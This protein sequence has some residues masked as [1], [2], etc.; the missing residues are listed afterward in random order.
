[1]TVPRPALA[2]AFA[3]LSALALVLRPAPVRAQTCEGSL[4][5]HVDPGADG[6]PP[7]TRLLETWLA[8]WTADQLDHPLLMPDDIAALN[9]RNED[10]IGAWHDQLMERQP[11]PDSVASELLERL[12]ELGRR[13]ATG[14]YVEDQPGAFQNVRK[15]IAAAYPAD[16]IRVVHTVTDFR[17]VPLASGL[18]RKHIDK[19]FDRNQCSRLHPGEIVRVLRKSADGRW[20]YGRAGHGVGWLDPTALGPPMTADAMRALRDATPR[21]TILDDWI[22][23]ER[24]DGTL[25][26]LR[27]GTGFP[28][29]AADEAR[30]QILVPTETGW[31][32]AFVARAP[33]AVEGY[34]PLTRRAF[35]ALL[36]ARLGDPYGW[37]GTGSGR[38]CSGL[39]LDAAASFDLRLGRNSSIQGQAGWTR[40]DVAG[41]ADRDKLAAIRA[42]AAQGVVFLYMPG[43][44]MVYLGELDGR[45]YAISAISEYLMP[46]PGGGHRTV[47]LDRTEVTD[48]ERGRGTERKAFIERITALSI[49]GR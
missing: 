9:S 15:T 27:F 19:L 6:T 38:D 12:D 7:V 31:D 10:T 48:L 11:S 14:E 2:L 8:Q 44:I 45:A 32:D 41:Q 13:V 30:W 5:W 17:C 33:G 47:R 42:A 40:V 25:H 4:G 36:F 16:E 3:A 22:P 18:Y 20:M 34:L 29:V 1:M 37:G 26:L 35:F 23:A 46:C 24:A 43:H 49:F 28:L 21:L 39:L